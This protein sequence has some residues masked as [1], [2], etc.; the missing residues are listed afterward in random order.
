MET[1]KTCRWWGPLDEPLGECRC[2]LIGESALSCNP[3]RTDVLNYP[4]DEGGVIETGPD[5]GC[6]HHERAT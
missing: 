6:V 1:C 2:P 3:G 4:Y 5:F